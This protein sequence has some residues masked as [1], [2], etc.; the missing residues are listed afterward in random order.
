[1]VFEY[2]S[3]N[4]IAPKTWVTAT[5]FAALSYCFYDGNIYQTTSGGTGGA[6]PPTHIWISF[7]WRNNW[8][9][10]NGM[11][12]QFLADTDTD[13]IDEYLVG[14]GV[15]W[16][17][18]RQKGLDYEKFVQIFEQ[19]LAGEVFKISGAPTLNMSPGGKIF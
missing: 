2:Q 17:F 3:T 10:F 7:R 12:T 4:W 18:M 9:Y 16:R 8:T 13:L 14:L 1:M 6:T 15:Q 5:P 11:Y 19:A